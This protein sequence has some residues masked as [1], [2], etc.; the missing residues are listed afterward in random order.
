VDASTALAWGLIDAVAEP[1]NIDAELEK[2][3]RPILECGPQVIRGQ[4]T[5]LR[6]WEDLS[7]SQSIALSIPA[8]GHAFSTG[9]PRKYMSQVLEKSGKSIS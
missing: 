9:E 5:L 7:L 6:K 2:M 8:F 1:D 3:I 4:K